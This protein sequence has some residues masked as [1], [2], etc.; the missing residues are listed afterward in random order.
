M[1]PAQ[2][3]S[4][5]VSGIFPGNGFD[6]QRLLEYKAYAESNSNHPCSFA[7]FA[8]VKTY[9]LLKLISR[10][11]NGGLRKSKDRGITEMEN[12]QAI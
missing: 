5:T 9:Y 3:K 8:S 4:R 12:I 6:E 7:V 10:K 2:Q 11:R 1:P